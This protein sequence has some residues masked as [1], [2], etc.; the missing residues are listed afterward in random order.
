MSK[1]GNCPPAAHNIIPQVCV[2]PVRGLGGK[3]EVCL[4]TSLKKQR[5]ILPKGAIDPGETHGETAAKE[6]HEE[7]GLRG[8]V[9]EP[10]LGTYTDIKRGSSL[11]VAGVIM[12]VTACDDHWP[13]AAVRTRQWLTPDRAVRQLSK[14]QHKRLL[15]QALQ[16]LEKN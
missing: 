10:A 1:S 16:R 13:E 4:V 9:I 14:P 15:R 11:E 6:A 5:W 3:V 2:V 12:E 8:R 7:A